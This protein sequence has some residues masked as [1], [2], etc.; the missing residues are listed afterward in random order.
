M[1]F[2]SQ[3]ASDL[4]NRLDDLEEAEASVSSYMLKPS[5]TCLDGSRRGGG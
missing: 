1:V 2:I 4:I 5:E 3:D